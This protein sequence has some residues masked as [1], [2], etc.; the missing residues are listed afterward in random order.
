MVTHTE[1][2]IRLRVF[3]TRLVKRV[4]GP[5]RKFQEILDDTKKVIRF[6]NC[7]LCQTLCRGLN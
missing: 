3:E 5:E 1:G 6:I 2:R 4:Y 7:T